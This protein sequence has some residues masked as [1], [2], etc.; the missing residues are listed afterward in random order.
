MWG[1]VTVLPKTMKAA[2]FYLLLLALNAN[3]LAETISE[4]SREY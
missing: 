2:G 3:F 1:E 4:I